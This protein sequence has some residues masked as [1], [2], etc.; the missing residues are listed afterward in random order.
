M[1]TRIKNESKSI[2]VYL[3][4]SVKNTNADNVYSDN[5]VLQSGASN[6]ISF[7][8]LQTPRQTSYCPYCNP[9]MPGLMQCHLITPVK[10]RLALWSLMQLGMN[11]CPNPIKTLIRNVYF[12]TLYFLLP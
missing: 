11:W 7:L 1:H 9:G 6:V 3:I 8:T 4:L 2:F 5:N 10:L 12:F